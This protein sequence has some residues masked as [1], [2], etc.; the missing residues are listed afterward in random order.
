M[1]SWEARGKG[2]ASAAVSLSRSVSG[3]DAGSGS[4]GRDVALLRGGGA[5]VVVSLR[6]AA[7]GSAGKSSSSSSPASSKSTSL[8]PNSSSSESESTIIGAETG[9]L[10][11]PARFA[12]GA[13]TVRLVVLLDFGVGSSSVVVA[14]AFLAGP[15][16]LKG[17]VRFIPWDAEPADVV[18]DNTIVFVKIVIFIVITKWYGT[19]AVEDAER[20]READAASR[21][22]HEPINFPHQAG[23]TL[24]VLWLEASKAARG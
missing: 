15:G 23:I 2:V 16:G 1:G 3:S 14:L 11:F 9:F 20:G 5:V 12:V 7:V 22:R 19:Q 8:V 13:E 21:G 6:G 24:S 4:A 10:P 17:R 18:R